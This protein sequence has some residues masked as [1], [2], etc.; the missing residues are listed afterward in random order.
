MGMKSHKLDLLNTLSP[1]LFT[2]EKSHFCTTC[3]CKLGARAT[4][5]TS[6][7]SFLFTVRDNGRDPGHKS[8]FRFGNVRK[9][10]YEALYD[11]YRRTYLL[12]ERRTKERKKKLSLFRRKVRRIDTYRRSQIGILTNIAKT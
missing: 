11:P 7:L 4:H 8:H 1:F 9:D 3:V 6:P 5:P 2:Y 12:F 10:S